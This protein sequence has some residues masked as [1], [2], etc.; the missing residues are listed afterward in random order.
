MLADWGHA[1]AVVAGLSA[2]RLAERFKVVPTA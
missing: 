1:N 2:E